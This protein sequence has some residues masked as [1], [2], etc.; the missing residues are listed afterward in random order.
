MNA[1]L[2]S[3]YFEFLVR[4]LELVRLLGGGGFKTGRCFLDEET[5]EPKTLRCETLT[6]FVKRSLECGLSWNGFHQ[7]ILRVD[8]G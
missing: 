4:E 1:M 2:G 5:Q 7:V 6:N 3:V 8:R